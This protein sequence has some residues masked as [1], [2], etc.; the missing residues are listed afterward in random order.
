MKDLN[1]NDDQV[2]I[3]FLHLLT[4][5]QQRIPVD[6]AEHVISTSYITRFMNNSTISNIS[7]EL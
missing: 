5:T 1:N 3:V 6:V 7:V 2:N 4:V